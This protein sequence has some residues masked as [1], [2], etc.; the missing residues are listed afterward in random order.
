MPC[1]RSQGSSSQTTEYAFHLLI[2]FYGLLGG[3]FIPSLLPGK[4]HY[5]LRPGPLGVDKKRR[6]E[7]VCQDILVI[8]ARLV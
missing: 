4:S 2:G 5:S 7:E 1:S 3:L 8:K 6:Q